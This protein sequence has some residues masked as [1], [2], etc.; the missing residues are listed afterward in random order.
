MPNDCECTVRLSAK[1][2][3][4]QVLFDNQFRFQALYPP[5]EDLSGNTEKLLDWQ[6]TNWGTKWDRYNYR[7]EQKGKHGLLLK[8][9]TAWSPPS[10]FLDYLVRTYPDIWVKCDWIEEGGL[11]GVYMVNTV[12]GQLNVQGLNWNDWCLEEFVHNFKE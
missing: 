11:A 5:P 6:I 10:S 1:E 8:F 12:D 4:I 9:T 3:T 2:E 7:V